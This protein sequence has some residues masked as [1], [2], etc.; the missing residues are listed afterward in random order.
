MVQTLVLSHLIKAAQ[1]TAQNNAKVLEKMALVALQ[2]QNQH[3]QQHHLVLR[4]NENNPNSD[5]LPQAVLT[6]SSTIFRPSP[7]RPKAVL[8]FS[9]IRQLQ[10]PAMQERSSS[11]S[12]R[13]FATEGATSRGAH[14]KKASK[15]PKSE[16]ALE[17]VKK[18]RQQW[19]ME[20]QARFV[21]AVQKL[22]PYD[23]TGTV[24]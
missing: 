3:L 11:S 23:E 1:D 12:A 22:A 24:M 8:P 10:L 6:T 20:E 9:P 21:K 5:V 13:A 14:V 7:L 16:A 19:T 18:T 2:G 15:P 17:A 4:G